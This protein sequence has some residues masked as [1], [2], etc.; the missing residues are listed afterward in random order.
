MQIE[1][2]FI[3]PKCFKIGSI[4]IYFWSNEYS[5]GELEP[6][7]V[8]AWYNQSP[9]GPKI[10]VNRKGKCVWAHGEDRLKPSEITKIER[11]IEDNIDLIFDEWNNHFNQEGVVNTKVFGE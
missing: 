11:A 6:I 3:M 7:H 4:I 8:H 9:N 2:V 5:G 10:W 1:G